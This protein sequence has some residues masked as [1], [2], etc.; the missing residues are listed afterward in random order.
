MAWQA[1]LKKTSI[2][3]ELLTNPDMF[4]MFEGGTPGGITQ[5]L[6]QYARASNK[7]MSHRFNSKEV[8][9]V[10]LY[11]DANNL[12][13]WA[14][15][16]LLPAGRFNWVNP[17]KLM[18]DNINTYANCENEDYLLKVDVKYPKELHNLHNDLLFMGEKTKIN[19]VKKLVSNLNDKKNY[20]VHPKMLNQALNSIWTGLFANLK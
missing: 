19:G 9:S 14:M 2:E 16:R 17:S 15:S 4:S 6:Y 8:I 18:S 20:V 10:L 7:Y 12:Y 13:G 1:C 3:L 5:A 11:L